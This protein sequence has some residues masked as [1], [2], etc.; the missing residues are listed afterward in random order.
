MQ[1]KLEDRLARFYQ[2]D[3]G[4]GAGNILQE[5]CSR[6]GTA[7]DGLAVRHL[8]IQRRNYGSCHGYFSHFLGG[9]LE[10]L[11]TNN[12]AGLSRNLSFVLFGSKHFVPQATRTTSN[13]KII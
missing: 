9:H 6:L 1:L 4:K 11:A 2:S 7:N 8:S 3:I 10:A 5:Q 12:Q 13:N